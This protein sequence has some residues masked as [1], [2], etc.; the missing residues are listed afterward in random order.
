[1]L[2]SLADNVDTNSA[3]QCSY[4]LRLRLLWTILGTSTLMWI[5][6]ITIMVF[7]AW[8]ETNDVFDDALKESSYLIMAATTDLNARG[9]LAETDSGTSETR[10]VDIQYQIVVDNKVI[11]RT[12]KAP[13][14]P[15]IPHFDQRKGFKNI[16]IDGQSW[17]IFVVRS[18]DAHFEVQVG[19]KFKKR[20]DILDE[21]AES[22]TIPALLLLA[23]VGAVSWYCVNRVMKPINLTAHA[24]TQKSRDDLTPVL[25]EEQ[26]TELKPVV[27]ALNGMLLRLDSALQAERRFTA[28]AAHELRTPLAA[29]GMHVQLLQRQH[30]ELAIPFQKLRNDVD[31]TTALVENLLALARLDPINQDGLKRQ[32]VALTPFLQGLIDAHAVNAGRR[33]ISV[34][35]Q[36]QVESLNINPELMYIALRNL[37]DN[38]LRYCPAK[39]TIQI[40]IRTASGVVRIAICDDGPGVNEE[41]HSRLGERFFRVLG[42]GEAGN[43]LGLSIVRRIAELHGAKLS[44]GRGLHTRG[45]GVFLDFPA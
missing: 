6:S 44:F 14:S 4:S 35:L 26:P 34:E 15:F 2:K 20:L 37:L 22:L 24:L 16:D 43:G 28:D 1:M 38:A 33:D 18:S 7:I 27:N 5:A 13:D 31:R 41:Q 29:I 32:S 23:M 40:K 39:S 10:K 17:R 36:N 12:T 30:A 19:Q 11:Q 9:L 8:H 45:L 42:S 3:K 21:L 25:L